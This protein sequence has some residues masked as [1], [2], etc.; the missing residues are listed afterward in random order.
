MGLAGFNNVLELLYHLVVFING[1]KVSQ[2]VFGGIAEKA[3]VV[4][5]L[6]VTFSHLEDVVV[7]FCLLVCFDKLVKVRRLVIVAV[8][9]RIASRDVGKIAIDAFSFFLF[10]SLRRNIR[11][12]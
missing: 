4:G 5:L 11:N 12:F 3:D 2:Q 7:I 9:S 10:N 1:L 6:A 8:S